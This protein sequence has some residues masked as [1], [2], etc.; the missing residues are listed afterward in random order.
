MTC[1]FCDIAAGTGPATIVAE[2]P[3]ALAILPRPDAAGRRGCTD[4]HILVLPRAHVADFAAD[5]M[6]TAATMARAAQLAARLAT[7]TTDFNIITSKG[8]AATQTVW[9]LHVHL[10][11]RRSGDGLALPWNNEPVTASLAHHDDGSRS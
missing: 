7:D 6:V 9:H 4:G 8:A 3:D 10:I 1:D 11:P 2:W 5:P